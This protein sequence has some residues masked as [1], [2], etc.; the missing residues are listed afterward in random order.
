MPVPGDLIPKK[1]PMIPDADMVPMSGSPSN[2]R[3]KKS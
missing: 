3:R 2:Q 1:V